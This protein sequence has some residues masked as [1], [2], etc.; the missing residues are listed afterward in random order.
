MMTPLWIKRSQ[1]LC[2]I[3]L[4]IDYLYKKLEMPELN[5]LHFHYHLT[6]LLMNVEH[7][8]DSEYP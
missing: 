8:E 3:F 4:A 1:E 2:H 5:Q 7:F 6:T